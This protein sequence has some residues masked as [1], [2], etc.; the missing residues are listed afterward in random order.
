MQISTV[1]T[2][3]FQWGFAEYMYIS[4]DVT[5]KNL[6]FKK[7]CHTSYHYHRNRKEL[8]S[9]ASGS[10]LIYTLDKTGERIQATKVV[11]GNTVLIYPREAHQIVALEDG[12]ITETTEDYSEHDTVRIQ[13]TKCVHDQRAL[14]D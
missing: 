4:R 6:H 10:F 9:I 2:R 5:V 7:D 8:L 13:L 3:P 12:I 14:V 11:A 1:Q